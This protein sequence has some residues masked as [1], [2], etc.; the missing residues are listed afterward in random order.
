MDKFAGIK[1][2]LEAKLVELEER[3]DRIENRLRDPGV[4]DWE[5]N[6]VLHGNDEVLSGLGDL[7]E[8]DIHEIRLALN[9]I[10]SGTYGIC[11]DCGQS[12]PEERLDALP[13]TSTC[14]KCAT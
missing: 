7:T 5:E 14:V 13:F 11:V 2:L 12:I 9:R 4:A 10:E 6:A 8:K 1:S 3:A